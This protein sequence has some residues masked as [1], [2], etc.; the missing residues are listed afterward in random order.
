MFPEPNNCRVMQEGNYRDTHRVIL[1]YYKGELKPFWTPFNSCVV[2]D[3]REKGLHPYQQGIGEA[4]HFIR[5]LSA[6]NGLVVDP[7]CGSGTTLV[8]A[9]EC[10]RRCRGS[11]LKQEHVDTARARLRELC[12]KQGR[13]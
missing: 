13:A 1:A 5:A 6:D 7:F 11:D 9:K 3:G 12:T 4:C 2:G 10:G 8:A